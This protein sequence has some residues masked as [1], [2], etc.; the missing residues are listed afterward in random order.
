MDEEDGGVAADGAGA[1]EAVGVHAC[2][3][4]AEEAGFAAAVGAF[5][6]GDA[7]GAEGLGD[8]CGDG[9]GFAFWF[10]GTVTGGGA[11]LEVRFG[12]VEGV[13]T[14]A[15]RGFGAEDGDGDES[16]EDKACG[17]EAP[18]E[19]A[20]FFGGWG[21]SGDP[22]CGGKGRCWG[23]R[24]W[25]R[26]GRRCGEEVGEGGSGGDPFRHAVAPD[27]GIRGELARAG[28]ARELGLGDF[29]AI[30]LRVEDVP[31]HRSELAVAW[32]R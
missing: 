20:A 7:A 11:G 32:D 16:A 3:G 15:A 12:F 5:G 23:T 21:G 31:V 26:R 29:H 4:A 9:G 13:G 14:G 17:D 27:E 22:A 8:F 28:D 30:A 18:F 19:A 1:G 10:G 2:G 24:R 25:W 6:V